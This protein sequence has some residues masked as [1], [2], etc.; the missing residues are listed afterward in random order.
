MSYAA[1]P[2]PDPQPSNEP[3]AHLT[4]CC[5]IRHSDLE[6]LSPDIQARSQKGLETYG[7]LLKPFNGRNQLIDAYQEL[8]DALV[9]LECAIR[10]QGSITLA[11]L[12][13]QLAHQALLLKKEINHANEKNKES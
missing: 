7:C 13:K 12:Q 5:K 6:A 9:Y 2:Q 10:E 3:G 8:L 1:Q 11:V 4:F